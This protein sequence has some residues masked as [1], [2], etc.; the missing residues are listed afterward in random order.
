MDAIKILGGGISGL[1]AAINLKK[2]GWDV[3]VHESKN[4]CGKNTKDFQFLENW[5]S[6]E[7]VLEFLKRMNIEVN[8]YHKPIK[9]VQIFSPNFKQYEGYSGNPLMYLV[10]RGPQEKSIDQSLEEQALHQGVKFIYNTKLKKNEAD[11]V[12]IG[13]K[14]PNIVTLGILFKLDMEDKAALILD[15]CLSPHYYSYFIVD[16]GVGE[17][18]CVSPFQEVKYIRKYL[19]E[20][21]NRFEIIFRIKV[22]QTEEFSAVGSFDFLRK[23]KINHQ[24]YIGEAAGFQDC[25]LG[26]GMVYAFKSG[27]LAAK[28]IIEKEDFDGL[29][30]KE[31]LKQLLVAE[32]NR[33]LFNTLTNDHYEKIVKLLNSRNPLVRKLLGGNDLR[34]IMK[35]ICNNSISFFLRYLIF[36]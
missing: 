10:K 15:N 19:Q 5:T 17:I 26:F 33:R 1:T 14:K 12:A 31:F 20:T 35:K 13:I 28:G 24:Y 29:W 9:K 7:N 34:L 4:Y 30:N 25:F 11:I 8:F 32:K 18:S 27:F 36:H 6:E 21:I 3:E 2:A 16:E 23:A 22:E